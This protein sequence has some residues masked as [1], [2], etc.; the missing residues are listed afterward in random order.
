[1]TEGGRDDCG[2]AHDC[3]AFENKTSAGVCPCDLQICWSHAKLNW[4]AN[5]DAAIKAPL[6]F[7]LWHLE[8]AD[9]KVSKPGKYKKLYTN[10]KA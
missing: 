9:R 6:E 3:K 7:N 8:L 5:W 4:D 1:M 2:Y 10:P